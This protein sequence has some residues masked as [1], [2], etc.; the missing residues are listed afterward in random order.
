MTSKTPLHLVHAAR[1]RYSPGP[2]LAERAHT[3]GLTRTDTPFGGPAWL[4]TRHEDV[5]AVLGDAA[6]FSSAT[7]D[8]RANPP[9]AQSDTDSAGKQFASAA[10]FL[11]G[12]DPPEHTRLRRLLTPEFT[13]RRMRELAPRVRAVVSEVLD[14]MQ[15]AGSPVDLVE[16]FALPVPSL[17]IC[18]LLGVPYADR[19]MFQ[20]LTAVQL[21]VTAAQDERTDAFLALRSYM[22]DLVDR[23]R[24]APGADLI[25]MLIREHDDDITHDELVGVALVLLIAGH[26][27]TANTLGAGTALLLEHPEQLAA[28]RDEPHQVDGAVEEL[29]RFFTPVHTGLARTVTTDTVIGGQQMK[30]GDLVVVSLPMAN[31]DPRL[32][33]APDDFDIA[34][35]PAPHVAFGHGIHHCVGAPLARM[36]LRIALPALLQRFPGLRLDLDPADIQFR[37]M[38][39]VHGVERLPVAW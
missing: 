5:R 13:M 30:T 8:R 22:G 25:G 37:T 7:A 21:R 18:E 34:R 4:V 36:E 16:R 11:V 19:E 39:A 9:A 26:E 3:D 32:V 14:A 38:T 28:V 2:A 35:K 1:E 23:H 33:T 24:S 29:L 6:R 10:S 12:Q 27:T 20:H 15:D 31:R 17:V